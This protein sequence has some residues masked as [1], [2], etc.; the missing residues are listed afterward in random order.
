MLVRDLLK[1]MDA[2]ELSD[3][4]LSKLSD[5]QLD[6]LLRALGEREAETDRKFS[7]F[8]N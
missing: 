2:G 3:E 6:E 8:L 1:K 4:E 7:R 5:E